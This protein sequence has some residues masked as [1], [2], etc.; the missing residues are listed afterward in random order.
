MNNLVL[1][2]ILLIIVVVFF[3]LTALAIDGDLDDDNSNTSS[4]HNN[5]SSNNYL[6]KTKKPKIERPSINEIRGVEGEEKVRKHLKKLLKNDEYLFSNLLL[7]LRNGHKTEID[8]VLL[9]RKGIFCVEIKNWIGHIIGDDS[10]E[11]WIQEYDDPTL[12]D[13]NHRNPYKQNESHCEILEKTLDNDIRVKNIVLFPVIEDRTN[14]YSNFTY[15]IK[16][17][18]MYY[19][20][21]KD[22]INEEDLPDIASK[23]EIYEATPEQLQKHKEYMKDTYGNN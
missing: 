22:E 9:S 8:C 3:V 5:K 17:F 11:D 13:K 23:L 20:S 19:R 18:M 2:I 16:E 14:L 15:E 7:P 1:P 21:L 4:K 12:E 6:I 10:S